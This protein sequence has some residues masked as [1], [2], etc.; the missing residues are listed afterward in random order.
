MGSKSETAS[1][2]IHEFENPLRLRRGWG[3]RV[4]NSVQVLTS[5]LRLLG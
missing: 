3:S 1:P 5:W 2:P 4:G